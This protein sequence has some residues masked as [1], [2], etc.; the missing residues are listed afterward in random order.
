[1]TFR[2][3]FGVWQRWGA[4]VAV[5][6]LLASC[7][8]VD[9]PTE[10]GSVEA[11]A[12]DDN[13]QVADVTVPGDA[14]SELTAGL[15]RLNGKATVQIMVGNKPITVEVDGDKAPYTAGNFVDLAQKGVYDGT[16]FHRVIDGFVAQGGDPLSAD[17]NVP[18]N[19]L[20]V[21]NYVDP[22]TKEV[23]SI[24]L[25]ILPEG[26]D[27]PVYGSTFDEVGIDAAPQ[28]SHT[29]GAIAMARADVNTA[30]A[31]FYITLADVT[32]PLDGKYA[33]FGYVTDGMDV[34]DNIQLEDVITSVKVTS[35]AENLVQP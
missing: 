21:G 16:I 17:P 10:V 12:Q 4:A 20:G 35:G 28:L 5:V 6:L 9:A 31:Q 3:M 22:E 14:A 11:P 34:V 7:T 32:D 13:A 30:S 26:A 18:V 8:A 1:M 24:P 15:P 19:Q 2:S 25:E 23:R 27:E 33:V 29:K